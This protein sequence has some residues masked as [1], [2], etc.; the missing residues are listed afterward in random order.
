MLSMLGATILDRFNY[1]IYL[2]LIII[3][4]NIVQTNIVKSIKTTDV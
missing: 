1:L 4:N 2:Y 3:Q